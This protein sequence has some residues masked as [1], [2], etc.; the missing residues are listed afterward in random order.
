MGDYAALAV[1]GQTAYPF[2]A[3][4]RTPEL[5][6][7]TGTGTPGNPPQTCTGP[8]FSGARANDQEVFVQRVSIP[9]QRP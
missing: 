5:F 1:T 2:W 8:G 3:D 9:G 6:L 7:C 4:T